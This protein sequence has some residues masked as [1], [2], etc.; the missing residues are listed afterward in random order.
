METLLS[1]LTCEVTMEVTMKNT[2]LWELTPCDE[3]ESH[4]HFRRHHCS[5][6]KL[7]YHEC[8]LIHG[9]SNCGMHITT[10]ILSTIIA[11]YVT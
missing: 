3:E 8:S 4:Y 1:I 7:F 6:G 5:G 2:V 11:L 10:A 9:F